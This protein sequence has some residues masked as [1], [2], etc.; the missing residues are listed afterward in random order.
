MTDV[1]KIQNWDQDF[2]NKSLTKKER[3]KFVLEGPAEIE[4]YT[5][6]QS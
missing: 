6:I 1:Y 5:Q 3:P 2:G 4:S